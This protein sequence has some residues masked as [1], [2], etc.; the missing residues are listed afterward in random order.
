MKQQKNDIV[1]LKR[2]SFHAQQDRQD[3][4]LCWIPTLTPYYKPK[5]V[6]HKSYSCVE[7]SSN[8][9]LKYLKIQYYDSNN[10]KTHHSV[11]HLYLAMLATFAASGVNSAGRWHHGLAK[12]A[13][14]AIVTTLIDAAQHCHLICLV[15]ARILTYPYIHILYKLH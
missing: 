12:E 2:D 7:F 8:F 9:N 14:L 3:E 15:K 6:Y 10:P 11:L 1:D 13:L 5:L 4:N